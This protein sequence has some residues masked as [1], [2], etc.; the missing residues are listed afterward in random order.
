MNEI[1]QYTMNQ[2]HPKRFAV[3]KRF[4]YWNDM[5]RKPGETVQKLVVRIRQAAATCDFA[6]IENPLDKA[7]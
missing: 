4:R 1:Q 3:H 7:L 5:K 6:N 2:F